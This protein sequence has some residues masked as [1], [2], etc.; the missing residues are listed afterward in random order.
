MN[1]YLA[2]LGFYL[3]AIWRRRWYSL[4][5]AWVVCVAGWIWV[6]KLPDVYQ[7]SARVY[8]DTDTMLGPLM[9]GLA[10]D[11]NVFQQID[12]MQ[13]TLL[14]RP[15]LEKVARMTDLD[16]TAKTSAEMEQ[17][18]ERLRKAISI[19]LQGTN[20]FSISYKANDP[21]LAKRVVQALLTIFVESQLGASRKDLDQARRFVDE[22]IRNYEAQLDRAEKKRAEFRRK[23]MALLSG[24]GGYFAKLQSEREALEKMKGEL[25]DAIS[26]RDSLRKQ[27]ADVPE[28]FESVDPN[29]AGAGL[30]PDDDVTIRILELQR[31]LDQLLL[32]YTDK[33]PDVVALKRR[34]EKLRQQQEELNAADSLPGAADQPAVIK[35]VNPVY[36]QMKLALVTIETNIA[37][38]KKRVANQEKKIEDL[39]KLVNTVP[40]VELELAKL[41]RD[42]GIIKQNYEKLLARREAARFANDLETKTDKIQFRIVDPPQIPVKPDGPN[43]LLY[44]TIVLIGGIGAG[45]GFGFVLSQADDSIT[46]ATRLRERFVVPVLGTI[47]RIA[48]TADRRRRALE[49]ATFMLVCFGLVGAY[50]GLVAVEVFAVLGDFKII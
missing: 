46:N 5:V 27:L 18:I 12:I 1:E 25:A 33:H 32:K 41:D 15:N 45:I 24:E 8:I 9:R 14:S 13:R 21:S 49:L 2:Q 10:V 29:T 7:S 22:Q 6:A 39:K 42:Y 50:G 30:A 43:R 3:R 31:T 48:S 28:F 23:N 20:L 34:L 44:L 37:T 36:Q 47:S 4:A 16:L 19:R 35:T 38:L 11:T 26:Q 17:L 40:A